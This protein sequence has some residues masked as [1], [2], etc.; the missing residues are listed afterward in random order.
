[1]AAESLGALPACIMQLGSRLLR[2]PE[3][4]PGLESGPCKLPCS[5]EL[6]LTVSG[7]Q[8]VDTVRCP[9]VSFE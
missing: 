1:M 6:L 2:F 7:V 9:R 3:S 8:A 4:P 5:S